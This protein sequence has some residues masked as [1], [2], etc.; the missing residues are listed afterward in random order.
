[1][2]GHL[3]AAALSLLEK[4]G[5]VRR[6]WAHSD[7]R[8]NETWLWVKPSTEAVEGW[9]ASNSAIEA[10]PGPSLLSHVLSPPPE[11]RIKSVLIEGIQLSANFPERRLTAYQYEQL[12]WSIETIGLLPVTVRQLDGD[13][14]GQYELINGRQVLSIA[15]MLGMKRIPVAIIACDRQQA[16]RLHVT[17]NFGRAPN[18]GVLDFMADR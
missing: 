9:L 18:A 8:P 11:P 2:H 5:E 6:L 1:M 14:E 15:Q 16:R 7:G 12:Q 17:L 10:R 3:S 4:G 13:S